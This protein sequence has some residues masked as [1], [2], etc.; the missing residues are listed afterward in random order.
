VDESTIREWGIDPEFCWPLI[1]SPGETDTIVV[2]PANLALKV[3][4]CRKAKG[5]LR[6]E[7]QTGTLRYIEWG[8]Q[9]EYKSGVQRGMKWPDGPWVKNRLPGWYALPES[10]THFSQLFFASAY[11]DRH[12][13]R[14]SSRSLIADKRL[15]FLSP[16][17]GGSHELVAAVMNS[18][19]VAFLTELAG[20]VT[21]GDGVLELTVEEARDYL[22]VPDVRQ[23]SPEARQAIVAA[24]QPLLGRPIGS[25][26]EEVKRADRQALDQAVLKALGLDP[27]AWLPRLYDGLTTLVRERA[28]LGRVRNK[29]RKSKRTRAANQVA[30]QVLADVLPDGP[31]CFPDDFWS[32]VARQGAFTE[33]ALPPAPLRYAGHMFGREE[34]VAEGGF[35]YQARSKAEAKYL[36][37][38]QAAGREVACLPVQPIE[39][40]RTIANYEQYVR[41]TREA[42]YEAYYHRTLDQK[43]ASRFV[44]SAMERLKLILVE[45]R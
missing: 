5:E 9:Q 39:L 10:E 37:Y 45:D 28:E 31:R 16:V 41:Q 18:S 34:V 13:H 23:F 24:F 38:A 4:V 25:V 2:D 26:F 17:G 22:R 35:H 44:A 29:A 20:R 40:S 21:L 14:F 3:F 8:E 42:L 32:A 27:V 33:V 6:A 19:L 15:Y 12:I 36:I 43:A 1:K 11:G 7:G 30:E